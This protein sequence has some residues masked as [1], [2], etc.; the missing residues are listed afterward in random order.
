VGLAPTVVH[1]PLHGALKKSIWLSFRDFVF[2]PKC[3]PTPQRSL[4]ANP[5]AIFSSRK[6]L[7]R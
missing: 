7:V 1:T 5:G 2:D 4:E 3:L 6:S